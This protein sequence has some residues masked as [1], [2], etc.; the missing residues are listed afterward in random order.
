M[1]FGKRQDLDD[2]KFVPD[3]KQQRTIDAAN[4][5][6]DIL[7][8]DAIQFKHSF[9]PQQASNLIHQEMLQAV[10]DINAR[11]LYPT[12]DRPLSVAERQTDLF[13][14]NT[15]ALG[16]D[17]ANAFRSDFKNFNA[18]EGQYQAKVMAAQEIF[19]TGNELEMDLAKMGFPRAVIVGDRSPNDVRYQRFVQQRNQQY[20]QTSPMMKGVRPPE[21]LYAPISEPPVA[22]L[23]IPNQVEPP[24]A[25]QRPRPADQSE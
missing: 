4:R 8:Q 20:F 17:I 11:G 22:P 23:V 14:Q 5:V 21:S 12:G 7:R 15:R 9:G 24:L 1:D 19:Q 2:R 13:Q 25:P 16:V 6:E 3:A 10:L 18:A